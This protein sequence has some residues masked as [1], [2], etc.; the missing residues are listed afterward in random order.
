MV[1]SN[2][3]TKDLRFWSQPKAAPRFALFSAAVM[4]SLDAGRSEA[5]DGCPSG[6]A[7]RSLT[8]PSAMASEAFDADG[9]LRA[10]LSSRG[11]DCFIYSTKHRWPRPHM[12]NK[13]T[14]RHAFSDPVHV[15]SAYRNGAC[16]TSKGFKCSIKNKYTSCLLVASLAKNT[17][18]EFQFKHQRA[19]V[20]L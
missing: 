18:F 12:Q 4:A 14:S 1:K 6:A 16:P 8:D 9:M 3:Y 19:H 13:P 5:P 17:N 20:Q 7:P 10:P 2:R 15:P 11:C